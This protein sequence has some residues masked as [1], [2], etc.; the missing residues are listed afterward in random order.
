M[1]PNNLI[2]ERDARTAP[3]ATDSPNGSG[4]QLHRCIAAVAFALYERRGR[5]DGHALDDWLAAEQQ[6][7]LVDVPKTCEVAQ[8]TEREA[9]LK[10]ENARLRRLV[11]ELIL[12]L[13]S[14]EEV[15]A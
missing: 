4:D 8:R 5:Q 14:N 15:W 11:G 2:Q 13:N 3:A 7:L 1:K 12:E 10:R 6:I 9:R